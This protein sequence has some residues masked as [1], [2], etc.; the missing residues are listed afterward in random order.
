MGT[1][2]VFYK[3]TQ[4]PE[5]LQTRRGIRNTAGVKSRGRRWYRLEATPDDVYVWPGDAPPADIR[6]WA[7]AH[8]P[9]WVA[10]TRDGVWEI[11]PGSRGAKMYP[12]G[13]ATV[14][15][16]IRYARNGR[17]GYVVFITEIPK[18]EEDDR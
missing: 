4:K 12:N 6:T 2:V 5:P 8:D 7:Y 15:D 10:Y 1:V 3:M 17:R 13:E 9:M 11:L 14:E 16:V 18:V